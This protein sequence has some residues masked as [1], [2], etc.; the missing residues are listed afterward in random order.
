MIGVSERSADTP[1]APLL[2]GGAIVLSA[3][4]LV[5]CLALPF[6][7]AAAPSLAKLFP[8]RPWVHPLILGIAAPLAMVALWRG[9]TRHSDRRPAVVGGVGVALLAMGVA[10]GD[11][12]LGTIITVFG[13]L[14][15]AAAHLHN[16]RAGHRHG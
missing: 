16:W 4:C 11:D 14:T 6:V 1:R 2:D 12:T 3:L 13:G 8:D 15:L 9:W 7:F 5:H 10:V